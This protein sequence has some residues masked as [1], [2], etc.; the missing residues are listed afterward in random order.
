MAIEILPF[1]PSRARRIEQFRSSGAA[2]VSLAHG[3]GETHVHV[4]HLAEGGVIG[5]HPA[6]FDQLLMVVEGSGWVAG[7]D[8]V[9]LD[10]PASHAAFILKGT[11]HSK[12]SERGMV[13]VMLQATRYTLAEP[14]M[15]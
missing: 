1:S 11:I 9:R 2:S 8:G 4:I 12:G 6:G 7:E 3:S 15:R 10:V 13:A 14:R 5:P